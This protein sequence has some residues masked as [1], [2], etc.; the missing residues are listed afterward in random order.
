MIENLLPANSLLLRLALGFMGAALASL[1]AVRFKAL[2]RS[3]GVAATIVG[4]VAMAA[5]WTFATVLLGFFLSA[6][7]L[8]RFRRSAKERILSSIVEKGSSRDA[9]QVLAN[10]GVF[11]AAAAWY[12]ASPSPAAMFA[13][14]GAV[15][16]AAAD[17]WA[18]EIGSLSRSQPRSI[19]TGRAVPAGTSGGVTLLG[20]GAAV[21]GAAFIGFLT[22]AAGYGAVLACVVSG[23]A[24]SITDSLLG[25]SLQAR[26]WC[27]ACKS[28]TE[29][30]VHSCGKPTS[31]VSGLRWIN[32]DT[33]NFVCTLVAAAAAALWVL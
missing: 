13:A 9:A 32:N 33:V 23:V 31:L 15:A 5:G 28:F 26:R 25:A 27:E 20:A 17:T 7:A 8:S 10:G 18:T 2:S 30:K 1:L 4:T 3:G 22:A 11:T 16:G 24:G 19:L 6:T 14:F 21:T 12:I 29:R